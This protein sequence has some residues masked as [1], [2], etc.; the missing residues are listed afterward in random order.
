MP[1]VAVDERRDDGDVHLLKTVYDERPHISMYSMRMMLA[2]TFNV[3]ASNDTMMEFMSFRPRQ[4]LGRRLHTKTSPNAPIIVSV[5]DL[6]PFLDQL[7]SLIADDPRSTVQRLSAYF[8][9]E[10]HKF[11]EPIALKTA[12]AR[13]KRR[14]AIF[15][16]WRV[17]LAKDFGLF[18]EGGL[19]DIKAPSNLGLS[20]IHI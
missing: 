9:V 2:V 12:I 19:S 18:R 20:L 16:A 7:Y 6:T 1:F 11:F 5:S 13:L 17:E 4:G 15:E 14:H 3:T 10:H 8:V